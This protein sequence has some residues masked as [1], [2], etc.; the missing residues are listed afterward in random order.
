MGMPWYRPTRILLVQEGVDYGWRNGSNKWYA[1]YP[2]APPPLCDI[3][4]GS[5]TGVVASSGGVLALDWTFGTAWTVGFDVPGPVMTGRAR[6][7]FSGVPLPLTDA[8]VVGDRT[9]VLTGGRGLPSTLLAL[10]APPASKSMDTLAF[11]HEKL[12]RDLERDAVRRSVS[13]LVS[14]L[15]LGVRGRVAARIALERCPVA[16]WRGLRSRQFP[17]DGSKLQFL[18]A[19]ARQGGGEDLEPVL[20]ALAG[21][22]FPGMAKADQIAWL[23][24]HALALLRLGPVSDAQRAALAARLLP[25]F[26][27]GDDRLDGDLAELLAYLDAPGLLDKA[28]PLLTPMRPAPPPP[29]AEV[30]ARNAN[31]GGAIDKMLGNMP[32]TG[33][34]AIANALRTVQHGWTLE[35]RRALFTFFAEARTRKGGASYDG[36]LKAMIDA[37]WETCSPAEQEQLAELVGKAKADLPKFQ[38]TPPKGPGRAWTL[39]A[40]VAAVGDGAGA[41]LTSGHNLFHAIGCASCHYF[42]GEGGNHGPDL[43]SLG[44][45]FSA[46]DVLE[47]ILEPSK[48]ISD[49]YSGSVV[50]KRDGSAV[51]G[52]ATK[53]TADGEQ[54]WEVVPAVADA[55]PVRIPVADVTGVA[56]SPQSPMPAALVNGLN[57]DE[58]RDLIAF[59]RSRGR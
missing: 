16:E 21:M 40:A 33:Q 5:P 59:L 35:Q 47:A 14:D 3:G 25:L 49:Q 22:S 27:A 44:N 51:F 53:V 30:A 15:G 26:P 24:V 50:S 23:R 18:L 52:R 34:I 29:W 42:A 46:R 28:L 36:Y 45:K 31:Y 48:V 7:A 32:P 2:D 43:T 19:L 58:L 4:P 12:R 11:V 38:S 55:V 1:D 10:P 37:A 56:P 54:F 20:E 17:S 57:P 9:F 41:D 8:V 39:D 6:E 13:Q